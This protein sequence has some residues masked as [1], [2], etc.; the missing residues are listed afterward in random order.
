MNTDIGYICNNPSRRV[1]G[2]SNSAGTILLKTFNIWFERRL[3]NEPTIYDPIYIDLLSR[4]NFDGTV[5]S[6][7]N[8]DLS[9]LPNGGFGTNEDALQIWNKIANDVFRPM[10]YYKITGLE[11]AL[12]QTCPLTCDQTC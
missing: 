10:L 4:L 7:N 11:T 6:L 2:N 9:A 5:Y 8:E 12:Q 1:N 3:E